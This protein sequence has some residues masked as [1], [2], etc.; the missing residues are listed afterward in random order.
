MAAGSFPKIG[1]G[2]VLTKKNGW[3]KV[4]DKAI[5]VTKKYYR[6]QGLPFQIAFPDSSVMVAAP[7]VGDLL[8]SYENEGHLGVPTEAN[9]LAAFV[10]GAGHPQSIDF[11]VSDFA[12]VV[13]PVM[14]A[15]VPVSLPVRD[16]YGS[17]V[18]A[19]SGPEVAGQA[20]SGQMY[21]FE[22]FMDLSDSRALRPALTALRL[23]TRG[24]GQNV[25]Y[26]AAGEETIGISGIVLSEKDLA[27]LLQKLMR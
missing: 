3:T 11:Y 20:E 22:G 23:L 9:P 25:V 16:F 17:F 10:A 18:P 21:A 13:L 6:Y 24:F 7:Q 26:S 1:L 8:A 14:N 19:Q 5:P 15:M 27:G 2:F 4:K 12:A